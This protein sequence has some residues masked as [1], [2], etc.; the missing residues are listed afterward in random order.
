M[1][2]RVVIGALIVTAATSFQAR[3]ED[4][5]QIVF[6]SQYQCQN[7]NRLVVYA[8]K[9]TYDFE[10]C[11]VQY[12]N[13]AAPGGLGARDNHV[14]RTSLEKTLAGWQC[15]VPGCVSNV[16]PQAAGVPGQALWLGNWYDVAVLDRRGGK[17]LVRFSGGSE[18]WLDSSAVRTAR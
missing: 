12:M 16:G 17:V 11:D 8:C 14:N 5:A 1:T 13:P 7:G 4:R 10:T 2:N 15:S 18:S 6:N 9:M 3:A